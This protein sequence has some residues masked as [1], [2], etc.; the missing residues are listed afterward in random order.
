MSAGDIVRDEKFVKR[1]E[2]A[3][4]NHHLAPSGHG[5]QAWLRQRLNQ[6]FNIDVSAEATRKWFAGVAK[7]RP[8]VMLALSKIL[9]VDVSWLSL[10]VDQTEKPRDKAKRSAIAAGAV[11]FVAGHIQLAGGNIAFPEG[12]DEQE[13][14]FAIVRGKR[15]AV[16]VILGNV[17]PK[18]KIAVPQHAFANTVLLVVPTKNPLVYEF[19]RLPSEILKNHGRNRSGH[20]EFQVDRDGDILSIEGQP[21]PQIR[22]FDNLDGAQVK[23]AAA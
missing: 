11:N 14:V 3:C 19:F 22:S 12:E 17:M 5:R 9:D 20:G 4:E 2:L 16:T 10:G 18:F 13:D 1:L 8:K 6:D 21:L 7:P 15:H 23:A